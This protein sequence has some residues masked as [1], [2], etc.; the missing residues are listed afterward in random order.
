MPNLD[1]AIDVL[2]LAPSTVAEFRLD[3]AQHV[4][5]HRARKSNA[6]GL[7][8]RFQAGSDVDPI[9][10]DVAPLYYHIA[11]INA[12]PQPEPTLAHNHRRLYLHGTA[13]GVH[14]RGELH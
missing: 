6:A 11:Y 1:R 7:S 14:C 4:F 13:H 3:P 9:A 10:Q 8:L 5:P 12:D 2:Q